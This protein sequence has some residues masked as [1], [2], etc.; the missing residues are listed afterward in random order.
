LP[1]P[2]INPERWPLIQRRL[3]HRTAPARRSSTSIKF[4]HFDIISNRTSR[5]ALCLSLD[6]LNDEVRGRSVARE[7]LDI[8]L[9][10][11]HRAA[12]PS[13]HLLSLSGADAAAP[14]PEIK[15]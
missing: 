9:S 10:T 4:C 12:E 5:Q 14:E 13:R 1:H 3:R 15:A 8:A 11:T 7:Q 2:R 6:L